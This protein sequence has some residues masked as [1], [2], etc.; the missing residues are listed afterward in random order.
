MKSLVAI[1][2]HTLI[3][4]ASSRGDETRDQAKTAVRSTL[5]TC[6]LVNDFIA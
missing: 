4:W 5:V 2:S 3:L 6:C 1:V